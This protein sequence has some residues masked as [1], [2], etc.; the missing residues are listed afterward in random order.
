MKIKNEKTCLICKRMFTFPKGYSYEQWGSRICCSATCSNKLKTKP[1]EDVSETAYRKKTI[2]G[3]HFKAHRKIIEEAC[4]INLVS[5]EV[6][7]H[8]NGKKGDN[9]IENLQIMS[10]AAHR[11]LHLKE[12]PR[13][14]KQTLPETKG[15]TVCGKKYTPPIK[16]RRRSKSC[17]RDCA[18]KARWIGRTRRTDETGM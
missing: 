10:D 7:H 4:G 17:S 3:K 15:C 9:R 1:N 12:K 2:K 14:F 11:A 16:H 8:I 18:L 5:D 13:G 6:V